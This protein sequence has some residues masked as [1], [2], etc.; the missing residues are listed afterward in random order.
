MRGEPIVRGVLEATIEELAAV[1]YGALR[2]EDVAARAG[3]NKTTI[4]RRWPTKQELVAAALR[5]VTLD[6]FLEPSTGSLRE[7]LLA[8]GRHMV[9]RMSSAEGQAVRRILITEERNPEFAALAQ[10]FRGSLEAL[11]APVIDAARRRKELK[12]QV[13]GHMLVRVLAGALQHRLF[14]EGEGANTDFLLQLIDLLLTG[15]LA[16]ERRG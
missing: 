9:Q 1:G 6:W 11:S 5:S 8:V 7:D 16:P 13:D 10:G 12:P 14:I 3:V 2:I 4:Y 15:A